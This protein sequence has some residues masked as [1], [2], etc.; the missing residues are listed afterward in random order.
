MNAAQELAM[1]LTVETSKE[2]GTRPGVDRPKLALVPGGDARPVFL[3]EVDQWPSCIHAV[4][5]SLV[6]TC[7]RRRPGVT[8]ARW[9]AYDQI[10]RGKVSLPDVTVYQLPD[11][12]FPDWAERLP[13]RVRWVYCQS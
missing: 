1:P 10:M 13:T 6:R 4:W 7:L 11:G 9:R 8:E 5:E 3:R 2:T 12:G